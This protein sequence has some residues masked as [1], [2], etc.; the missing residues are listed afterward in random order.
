MPGM[1]DDRK[2]HVLAVYL[3]VTLLV[4]NWL[5]VGPIT[6]LVFIAFGVAVFLWS[7]FR[8]VPD[9]PE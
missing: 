9:D 6:Y 2:W 7:G 8:D 4:S 3:A 5:H 1:T